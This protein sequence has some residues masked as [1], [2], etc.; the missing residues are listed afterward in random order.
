[1]SISMK[2]FLL[3]STCL[4]VLSWERT[5]ARTAG[6]FSSV[7][8]TGLQ[9]WIV[10][11]CLMVSEGPWDQ[12]FAYSSTFSDLL[13]IH[14]EWK[15]GPQTVYSLFYRHKALFCDHWFLMR[16]QMFCSVSVWPHCKHSPIALK[17]KL[18]LFLSL[19]HF[20]TLSF[21]FSLL[22]CFA[23]TFLHS[24]SPGADHSF[25]QWISNH[26]SPQDHM[27]VSLLC[28]MDCRLPSLPG[29]TLLPQPVLVSEPTMHYACSRKDRAC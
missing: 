29:D 17:K 13:Y 16:C 19:P 26:E 22:D 20:E 18:P 1:M 27:L 3:V 9:Y 15:A 14:S 12:P 10:C 4:E 2:E 25:L 7:S 24:L 6:T 11:Q 28:W 23:F 5:T 21:F 8:D